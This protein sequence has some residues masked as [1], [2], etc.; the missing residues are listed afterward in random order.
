[1]C[2]AAPHHRGGCRPAA[3][4]LAAPPPPSGCP[5]PARRRRSAAHRMLSPGLAARQLPPVQA[6]PVSAHAV[7]PGGCGAGKWGGVTACSSQPGVPGRAVARAAKQTLVQPLGHASRPPANTAAEHRSAFQSIKGQIGTLTPL[8][9]QDAP[10]CPAACWQ[11]GAC[12]PTAACG[13]TQRLEPHG[14]L[15]ACCC[16][17]ASLQAE[18]RAGANG[19]HTWAPGQPSSP[20]RRPLGCPAGS[21][22]AAPRRS[23]PPPAGTRG[24]L[25]GPSPLR[26]PCTLGNGAPRE[27]PQGSRT[28]SERSTNTC[29]CVSSSPSSSQAVL[30]PGSSSVVTSRL[31]RPAAAHASGCF[32][33]A[34]AQVQCAQ[35]AHLSQRTGLPRQ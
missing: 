32:T 21:A 28:S 13:P 26:S 11:P 25:Q 23:P 35:R 9:A 7:P 1:V 3:A 27:G 33:T 16:S 19:E 29:S 14:M 34:V 24:V 18:Q 20:R 12:P 31:G 10:S 15:R 8:D 17:P 6:R 2:I 5:C 30:A 4:A 22:S